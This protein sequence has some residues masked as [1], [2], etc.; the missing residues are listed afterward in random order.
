MPCSLNLR[1]LGSTRV[2]SEPTASLYASTAVSRPRPT[3]GEVLGERAEALV[4]LAAEL[5]D[6]LARDSAI[7]SWRQPYATARSSAISVVGVAMITCWSTPSS[8]SAGSCS[9]AALEERLAGEE[10]DDEVG[11][12][13]RTATSSSSPRA[14]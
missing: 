10:E 8:I 14:S 7:V 11:R 3:F 2:S 9:S 4:E 6:R 13:G 12:L 5:A 1:A